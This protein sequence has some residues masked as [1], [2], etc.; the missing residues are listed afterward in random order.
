MCHSF[1]LDEFTLFKD[2]SFKFNASLIYDKYKDSFSL[3][4]ISDT[5]PVGGCLA[6]ALKQEMVER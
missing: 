1:N 6:R 3:V 2:L 4:N 5:L